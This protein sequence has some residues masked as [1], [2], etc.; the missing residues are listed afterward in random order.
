MALGS[1]F[2]YD[3]HGIQ[4]LGCHKRDGGDGLASLAPITGINLNGDWAIH[5]VVGGNGGACLWN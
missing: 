2:P 3:T 1:G 5:P 4:L